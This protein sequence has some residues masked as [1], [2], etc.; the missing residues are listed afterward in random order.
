MSGAFSFQAD[1]AAPRRGTV[2]RRYLAARTVRR[3]QG[4]ADMSKSAKSK[5]EQQFAATQKKAKKQRDEKD[6]VLRE[7]QEKVARLRALRLA[8]EA[9]DAKAA[10]NNAS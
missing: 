4:T 2:G 9:A 3:K 6:R 1:A 7:K 10:E 8:K 5:A